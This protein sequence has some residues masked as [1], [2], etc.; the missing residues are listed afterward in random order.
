MDIDALQALCAIDDCGGVTRAA[1]HL[2]ITQPA[3]SHK[4]KRLES[5][6]GHSLLD[7]R[8]GAPQFTDDGLTLLAY[9]RRILA[10]HDEA[11]QSLI[12]QPVSGKIRLG[13]TEDM[14][15]SGLANILARFRRIHA[16]V[17]VR[18]HV[19]QSAVLQAQ[20]ASG[21]I[22]MA[23]MQVFEHDTRKS[24]IDLYRDR[25]HWVKSPDLV[26]DAHSPIP[27]LAFDK[28]CFYKHWVDEHRDQLGV[29]FD[30]VLQCASHAGI[31]AAI[32]AG[33]GV[34]VLNAR[35]ISAAMEVIDDQLELSLPAINYVIRSGDQSRSAAAA[36]LAE[37]IVRET[38]QRTEA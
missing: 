17:A 2:S 35:Y 6:L 5:R 3:V 20:L 22:D 24:D 18:T 32:D 26:L 28:K 14:S 13:M 23:V 12:T 1:E 30:T 29:R 31:V 33:M 7:R 38:S 37:E 25:L 9:A 8:P 10:L 11:V 15:T 27:F 19:E 21:R 16:D 34:A 4:I 36:A